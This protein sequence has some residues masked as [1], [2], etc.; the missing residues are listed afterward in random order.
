MSAGHTCES[1]ALLGWIWTS[2]GSLHAL[3]V[4]RLLCCR[5]FVRAARGWAS[6]AGLHPGPVREVV[7]ERPARQGEHG[8]D[9]LHHAAEEE[10]QDEDSAFPV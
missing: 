1:H 5:N 2:P 4:Q 3:T 10:S 7:G 9:R 6:A 8:Q